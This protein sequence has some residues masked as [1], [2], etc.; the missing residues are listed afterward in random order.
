MSK[1]INKEQFKTVEFFRNV[2]ERISKETYNMSFEELKEYLGKRKLR[3][4]K[5]RPNKA[6]SR[7]V[8]ANAK[9]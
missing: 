9:H 7:L 8:K 2:K 5:Y 1:E 4:K 3:T 6:A